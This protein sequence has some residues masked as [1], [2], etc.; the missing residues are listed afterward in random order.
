LSIFLFG[1]RI[2]KILLDELIPHYLSD[3]G[4]HVINEKRTKVLKLN[5]ITEKIIA[6]TREN[7]NATSNFGDNMFLPYFQYG[8]VKFSRQIL[9]LDL[10]SKMQIHTI[11]VA[12]ATIFSGRFFSL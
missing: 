10:E 6:T 3:F 4:L 2:K 11:L 7:Y 1:F 12:S 8:E 9:L 5:I